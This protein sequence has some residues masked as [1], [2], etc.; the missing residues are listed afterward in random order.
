MS[1]RRSATTISRRPSSVAPRVDLAT[2]GAST[3]SPTISPWATLAAQPVIERLTMALGPGER[4]AVVGISGSGKTT[5]LHG[6]AGLLQPQAG[7]VIVDG[8]VVASPS[9][10]CTSHHAAYMFQRDL[11]LP[12]KTARDNAAFAVTVARGRDRPAPRRPRLGPARYARGRASRPRPIW[13]SSDWEMLWTPTRTNCRG[14]CASGWR[15]PG[16]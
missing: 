1:D 13:S 11:L 8:A 6:L 10:L 12:W 4:V 15:W 16:L 3:S 5:L 14:A 9:G 2:P 7:R